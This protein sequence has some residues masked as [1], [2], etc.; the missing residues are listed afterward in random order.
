MG[1]KQYIETYFAPEF[2][3]EFDI[4]YDA[5]Q[6]ALWCYKHH[7][8]RPCCTPE[9]FTETLHLQ[10]AV[11]QYML[12]DSENNNRDRLRFFVIASRIPG[13]FNVGG[14]LGLLLRLVRTSDREGLYNYAK[15]CIDAL[16]TG[17][18][19]PVT[20]ISLVQGDA[21]GGGF[22]GALVSRVLIAER[23]VKMGLPESLFNFF[24][25]MGAY[26][27]LTRKIGQA[28]AEQMILSGRTYTAPELHEMGVV[29]ILAENGEGEKA[30]SAYIRKQSRAN[31]SYQAI[32]KV[33]QIINPLH[34]DEL[35][36]V[37]KV[38]L[39]AAMRLSER[40]LRVMERIA[41]S[42]EKLVAFQPLAEVKQLA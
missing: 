33:R 10:R 35:L 23:Q 38:W 26:S 42:Q 27:L 12:H 2:Y 1:G 28:R 36:Q 20:T 9:L 11:E 5:E 41:Q 16:Y 4:R 40:D 39:D 32:H 31:N 29:D 15:S 17:Y 7:S 18:H 19:L 8:S 6:Q 34:Y 13:I 25:G 3:H 22:E 37:A 24:P 21:F 30:V 14:D